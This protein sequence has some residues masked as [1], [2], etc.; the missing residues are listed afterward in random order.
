MWNKKGREKILLH[1][2]SSW[3]GH[4]FSQKNKT[5]WDEDQY[6]YKFDCPPPTNA[7]FQTSDFLSSVVQMLM[8][9]CPDNKWQQIIEEMMDKD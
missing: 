5:L 9:G 4:Y 6:F 3:F 2:N 1:Y 7:T 8:H